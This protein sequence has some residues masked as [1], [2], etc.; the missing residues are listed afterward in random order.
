MPCDTN[1]VI[2]LIIKGMQYK[3]K[4]ANTSTTKGIHACAC[5]QLCKSNQNIIHPIAVIGKNE[6]LILHYAIHMSWSA[7]SL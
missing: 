3:Y 1:R 6:K 4:N 5:K 2:I 7:F